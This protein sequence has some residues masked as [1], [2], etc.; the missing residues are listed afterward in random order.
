M[1]L[2]TDLIWIACILVGFLFL[3]KY[4]KRKF[5]RTNSTGIEQFTDFSGKVKSK[6]KDSV[7]AGLAIIFIIFGV[8][9]LAFSY[10]DTW[11]WIVII[12]TVAIMTGIWR[13]GRR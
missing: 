7:L 11:G 5:D 9:M 3:L 8:M 12:P 6:T 10:K 2:I 1:G 4:R 13:P